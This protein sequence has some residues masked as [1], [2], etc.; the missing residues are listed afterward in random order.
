M[1]V[2]I[3]LLLLLFVACSDKSVDSP[4][5][6]SEDTPRLIL[7]YND[8]GIES[9]IPI[10]QTDPPPPPP[11]PELTREE[12]CAQTTIQETQA[13]CACFPDCCDRQRWYCPPNPRQTIDVMQVILEVCDEN[14]QRCEFGVDQDCPPPEII[15]QSEC[16][17]QWECPPGTSGEFIRWFECQ[18]EDGTLGQQQ[19]ICDKGSLRHMPCRP[20]DPESCDTED[21]DCDG[22]VDEGFFDCENECGPG[23]GLCVEG[24]VTQCN[25]A[26]PGEERCNFE[27]DDCDG[28]IDEGQRNVCDLCGPVPA[29]TCDGL[30]N[31]CDGSTDEELIRECETACGR[32]VETCDGGN[33]IS[34][35]ATQP[36]DEECD[37]EDNDCDGQV[38]EQLE[39]LCTINDVGNLQPCSEPP[40]ICGQGFKTCECVDPGCT[41]MRMTECAALCQY[42]P[43]PEPPVC[44]P[45]VGI[46]LQ[47]EECNNF[48]E[49]CDQTVDENLT[50][51]CYTGDPET[52]LVGV[53]VP[54][55]VYCERGAWGNDRNEQFE[56]GFCLGEITPQEE[57]C[58]GADNDCDGV[59]DYGEEIRET[60]ILFIVD[61]SG[62]MDDEIAAVKIALNRFA[63]HFA[64]EEPLQWG[65]IIG[66]KEFEEDGDE[67][68]VKVSD[69]SPFDQFL[70]SFAALGSEGMD[71]GNEMLLD[72]VY[73]AVQNI[74]G[75]ANVDI[76]ATRW[77]ADTGSRPAKEN[78][79]ITWRPN[80]ERI[81]I[82]FSDEVEQSFLQHPARN[83][84]GR[85]I[86]K[87][88]VENAVSAGIRLKVYAFSGGGWAGRADFWTDISTAG[89]GANFDLTSNA[90]SMYND[91][92]SI[93]DEA[94]LPREDV[95]AAQ[96]EVEFFPEN[97]GEYFIPFY[98]N[99]VETSFYSPLFSIASDENVSTSFKV[100]HRFY[101]TRL[102]QCIDLK[103][104]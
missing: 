66:P 34:C 63:T 94:C 85:P 69:I 95:Q 10:I 4:S 44:D 101:D 30:D 96:Q 48:D 39:C 53:C 91:L 84:P 78:F 79:S 76:A 9:D 8:A 31:D 60:D 52:L 16:M 68:L 50:Q 104:M 93:I 98:K 23:V 70:A 41:E 97:S 14:K 15:S 89:N 75:N 62:S 57:I 45:R 47:Q 46:A 27:D 72:A 6:G 1:R 3:C 12:R 18:L 29:D 99:Y 26:Q 19:I 102:L 59:V 65:L 74:S 25:A 42:V 24:Q 80:S 35:T 22:I 86:T 38:D 55:E 37:G 32:G 7:G 82:I 64:A 54:G 77:F 49:D 56:P 90:L 2:L 103:R 36:T 17:T 92:M 67:Y 100:D 71:T 51:A 33:W 40:L 13:Y 43:M 87:A 61:W 73:L 5:G 81:V 88:V 21:N 11:E 20:C 28:N 83:I 58:D